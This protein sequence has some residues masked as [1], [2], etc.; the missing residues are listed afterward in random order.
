MNIYRFINSKDI[1]SYLEGIGYEFSSRRRP[2]L[3][4][5]RNTRR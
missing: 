3:P 2:S 4:T 1:A 5:G